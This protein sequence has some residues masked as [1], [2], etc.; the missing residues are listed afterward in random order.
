MSN[1]LL[2]SRLR[3]GANMRGTNSEENLTHKICYSKNNVHTWRKTPYLKKKKKG[4]SAD[5]SSRFYDTSYK[6]RYIKHF[7]ILIIKSD[8]VFITV[9]MFYRFNS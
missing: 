4:K 8:G 9:N 6:V 3:K 1:S 5:L 2:V 7:D